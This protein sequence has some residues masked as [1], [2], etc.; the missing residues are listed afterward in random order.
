MDEEHQLHF[1]MFRLSFVIS[2]RMNG[3]KNPAEIPNTPYFHPYLYSRES[4]APSL[5]N[6]HPAL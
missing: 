1:N 2:T 6:T 3:K 4:T 5:L